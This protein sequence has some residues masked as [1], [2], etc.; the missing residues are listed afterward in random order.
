MVVR[1]WTGL[2]WV[3]IGFV[4]LCEDSINLLAPQ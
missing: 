2:N 3:R 4:G 1:V